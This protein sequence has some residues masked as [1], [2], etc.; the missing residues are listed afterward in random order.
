MQKV[1]GMNYAPVSQGKINV[2]CEKGNFVFSVIGLD[3]GHIYAMCNGLLEAG[4]VLKEVFDENHKKVEEFK[5]KYPEVKIAESM[6]E[7]LDDNNIQMIVSAIKPYKRC[8][9][10]ILSMKKG[11]DFFV[12]K[13]GMLT[14]DEIEKVRSVCNE[15]NRKYVIYFG[16]RIHVEGAIFAE[17]LIKKGVIGEVIQITILAPHRLNKT[18]RPEWFFDEKKNGG[19]ITDLG[20]HQIEQF[21]TFAGAKTA[22]VKSSYLFNYSNKDKIG[23]Y[24]YGEGNLIADNGATC[25]FQVHWFTPEGL[26]AWGDGRVFILGIKGYIEIRKYLDISRSLEGDNVFWVDNNGEHY[27]N[28]TGKIGFLFFGELI[29]DCLNRTEDIMTQEHILEAMKIA[30]L[31][32]ENAK[33]K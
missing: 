13:P 17:Q 14:L 18:S 1:D 27:E 9:L 23:F 19:I 29:L 4:G 25:Y 15:T 10:G 12:D 2:V 22:K 20:S 7:I 33:I 8:E 16:E 3:H 32:E 28:V 21:L 5:E 11:K 6:E 31:A 26:R 24:D 30:I